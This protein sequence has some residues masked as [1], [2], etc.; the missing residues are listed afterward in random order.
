MGDIPLDIMAK[1]ISDPCIP[2]DTRLYFKPIIG[3]K[4]HKIVIPEQLIA[5]LNR[6]MQ[7]RVQSRE[8]TF[9]H[10]G[11]FQRLYDTN[12]NGGIQYNWP[13]MQKITLVVYSGC[14]NISYS[15]YVRKK[16][17]IMMYTY[18]FYD[19]QWHRHEKR[20]KS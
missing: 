5:N 6:V 3:M 1:I 10:F 2:I 11:K 14:N 13:P 18:C 20:W 7:Y 12:D 17:Y 15:I 8:P 4:V 16:R 9:F 19:F